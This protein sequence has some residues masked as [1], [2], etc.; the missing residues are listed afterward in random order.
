[1]Y[2]WVF[3]KESLANSSQFLQ[4]SCWVV[5]CQAMSKISERNE[6]SG[7]ETL[8]SVFHILPPIIIS[9]IMVFSAENPILSQIIS[10][11]LIE[12]CLNGQTSGQLGFGNFACFL[13]LWFLHVYWHFC[14]RPIGCPEQTAIFLISWIVCL[15]L[16]S[17][18]H[19]LIIKRE[20]L[21]L[22]SLYQE[23]FFNTTL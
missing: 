8:S 2:S 19:S 18:A 10:I 16:P 13:D 21:I 12:L 7:V 14:R 17:I 20:T 4:L 1:M 3:S 22:P 9:P 6:N 5:Q 11:L 15:L 23:V